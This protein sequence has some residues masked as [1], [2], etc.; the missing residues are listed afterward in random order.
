MVTIII[1]IIGT[2]A[3]L[4]LKSVRAVKVLELKRKTEL[5]SSAG[6]QKILNVV[7]LL[8]Y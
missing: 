5:I 1:L 2:G 8:P 3:F 4:K 6:V 7:R